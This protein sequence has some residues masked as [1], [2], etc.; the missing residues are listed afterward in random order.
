MLSNDFQVIL[1]YDSRGLTSSSMMMHEQRRRVTLPDMSVKWREQAARWTDWIIALA[2]GGSALYEIW[3][4]PIFDEGIPGPRL[5]N[6]LLFLFISL[7]FA[8]RRRVPV[9]VLFVVLAAIGVQAEFFD[10][11]DQAPLQSFLALLLAFYSVAAH[12]EPRRAIYGGTAAGAVVVATDL[13]S[14]FT[15]ENPGDIIPAWLF[16]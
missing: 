4:H 7:P 5:T 1:E 3:L 16:S 15:G 2:L 10:T 8:W 12:G 14:L 11:S 6:T 9:A 13:P